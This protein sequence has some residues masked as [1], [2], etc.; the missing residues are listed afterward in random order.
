MPH[1]E[2]R[3]CL[4][5]AIGIPLGQTGA[6]DVWLSVA[7]FFSCHKW[8]CESAQERKHATNSFGHSPG[9]SPHIAFAPD[10]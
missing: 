5:G 7:L 8:T 3:P 10:W 1:F 9:H 6:K 4:F 2:C